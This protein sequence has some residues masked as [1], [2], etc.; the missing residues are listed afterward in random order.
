MNIL[1]VDM[2]SHVHLATLA[3]RHRAE[4]KANRRR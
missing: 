3:A 2:Q 1:D 4:E